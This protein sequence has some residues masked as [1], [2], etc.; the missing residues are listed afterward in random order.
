MAI[1]AIANPHSGA[2]VERDASIY[3]QKDLDLFVT[4]MDDA[5]AYACECDAEPAEWVANMV[6]K[7]GQV[8]AGEIILS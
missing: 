5:E 7:L 3:T 6:D 8:R 2:T 1:V 4:R